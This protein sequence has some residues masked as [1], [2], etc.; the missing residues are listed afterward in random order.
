MTLTKLPLPDVPLPD[1]L[2]CTGLWKLF[3]SRR[4]TDHWKAKRICL[5]CPILDDCRPPERFF[6]PALPGIR[7]RPMEGTIAKAN[8]TWGGKLYRDGALVTVPPPASSL[9]VAC[10]LCG[11][12]QDQR[13]RSSTGETVKPHKAR[14]GPVLCPCGTA[15]PAAP[16][17]RYCEPCRR[18]ARGETYEIRE[19]RKPTRE[20][21]R[22]AA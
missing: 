2:P 9:P 10:G 19:A 15:E 16:K 13:C 8:G 20:R 22:G 11:A 12:R 3:D 5:D 21:R 4:Q 7:G 1:R 17:H 14:R 18:A 6:I